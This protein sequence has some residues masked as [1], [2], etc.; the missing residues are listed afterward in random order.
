MIEE[1]MEHEKAGDPTG[2]GLKWIR[3]TP[4]KIAE[5]L[6]LLGIEVSGKTVGSLLKELNYLKWTNWTKFWLKTHPIRTQTKKK[7]YRKPCNPLILMV[8]R[9]GFEP[10]TR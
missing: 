9:V 4:E 6:V 5:Q 7:G 1:I 10:T 2:K 3:R 8:S